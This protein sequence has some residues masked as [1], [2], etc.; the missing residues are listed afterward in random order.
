MIAAATQLVNLWG[1]CTGDKA[2]GYEYK[3]ATEENEVRSTQKG[4]SI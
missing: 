1:Y 4:K 2:K 3:P